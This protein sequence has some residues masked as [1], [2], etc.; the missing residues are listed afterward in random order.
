MS[1]N[2]LQIPKLHGFGQNRY[3]LIY[4]IL[5]TMVCGSLILRFNLDQQN[6]RH[7]TKKNQNEM[8]KKYGIH[9][10]HLVDSM[11]MLFDAMHKKYTNAEVATKRMPHKKVR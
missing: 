8:L 1:Q 5:A 2:N 10:H 9:T 7:I 3:I 6:K 4:T 11:R